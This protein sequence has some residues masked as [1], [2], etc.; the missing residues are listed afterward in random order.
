MEAKFK[1]KCGSVF[2]TRDLSGAPR[3]HC[4][5]CRTG[6]PTWVQESEAAA[7]PVLPAKSLQPNP[8]PARAQF[9]N[10]VTK[11][12]PHFPATLTGSE[13][14]VP[15]QKWPL[16]KIAM[17]V[18][19]VVC[20]VI[21]IGLALAGV[22]ESRRSEASKNWPTVQGTVVS[23]DVRPHQNVGRY[24]RHIESFVVNV[25]YSYSVKGQQLYGKQI[26]MGDLPMQRGEAE[27]KA[28]RFS[29]GSTHPV[30]YDPSDPAFAVLVPG[31]EEMARLHLTI[32]V[33]LPAGLCLLCVV[34]LMGMVFIPN[35][36]YRR[37]APPNIL[38]V[39]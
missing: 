8:S 33:A 31:Y 34:L 36:H 30:Y 37:G 9:Q 22:R 17:L 27:S 12:Q 35:S 25:Q 2:S 32:F 26:G 11:G 20:F 15:R 19:F 7:P 18:G 14:S 38:K 4:P 39:S 10:T 6:L 29:L 23:S 28:A 21:A 24:S 1:C 5:I 13:T 16:Q 3:T